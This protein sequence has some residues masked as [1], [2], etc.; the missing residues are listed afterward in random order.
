MFVL[1]NVT[2]KCE[3]KKINEPQ[4]VTKEQSYV[5]LELHNVRIEPENMRKNKGTAKCD[6]SIVTCDVSTA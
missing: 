4:N 1:P 3:K 6:K 5:I 2:I